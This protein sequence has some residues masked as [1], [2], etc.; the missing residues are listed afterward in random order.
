MDPP[1]IG[2]SHGQTHER[3]EEPAISQIETGPGR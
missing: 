2:Q 3:H 1:K